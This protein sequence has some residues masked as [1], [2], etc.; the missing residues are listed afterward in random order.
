MFIKYPGD[1]SRKKAAA[2][3]G[4]LSK[5]GGFIGRCPGNVNLD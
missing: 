2:P 4:G 3:S 1:V 5:S